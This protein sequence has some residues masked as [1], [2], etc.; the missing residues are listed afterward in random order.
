MQQDVQEVRK[1]PLQ[2]S[3][4]VVFQQE[5]I[6]LIEFNQWY[7]SCTRLLATRW[8]RQHCESCDL[9]CIFLFIPLHATDL[10]IKN[11]FCRCYG[12]RAP[13][14]SSPNW[15]TGN[16]LCVC[17]IQLSVV[18]GCAATDVYL[19]WAVKRKSHIFWSL[20]GLLPTAWSCVLELIEQETFLANKS[21]TATAWLLWLRE[22]NAVG[23]NAAQHHEAEVKDGHFLPESGQEMLWLPLAPTLL[24]T[25]DTRPCHMCTRN[26]GLAATSYRVDIPTSL[27]AEPIFNVH[28]FLLLV[29]SYTRK[30][31]F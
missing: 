21:N 16:L 26:V 25:W 18:S 4:S 6:N 22:R 11:F 9:H 24:R 17:L 31:L 15:D 2:D 12:M 30:H 20:M 14:C 7:R 13:R 28:F 8:T 23:L 1:P 27:A 29:K 19:F 3:G 5:N 10:L